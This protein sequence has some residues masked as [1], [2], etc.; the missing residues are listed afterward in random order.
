MIKREKIQLGMANK[1]TKNTLQKAPAMRIE[2]NTI[3]GQVFSRKYSDLD[4]SL[5]LKY[6]HT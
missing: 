1:L 5:P 3:V 6:S 4:P 2:N